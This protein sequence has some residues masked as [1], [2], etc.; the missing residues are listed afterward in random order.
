MNN[1]IYDYEIV[2]GR[3]VKG[4]TFVNLGSECFNNEGK[5]KDYVLYIV[6]HEECLFEK[7]P[8]K[9]LGIFFEFASLI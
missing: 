8:I 1:V 3:S 5:G 7:H 9:K 4:R 2:V 6:F